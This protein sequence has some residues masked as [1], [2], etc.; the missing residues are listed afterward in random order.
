MSL[1]D[2]YVGRGHCTSKATIRMRTPPEGFHGFSLYHPVFQGALHHGC[3]HATHCPARGYE[4]PADRG[5]SQAAS[6]ALEAQKCS[7]ERFHAPSL[8]NR[9]AFISS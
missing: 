4:S 3:Q 8:S 9:A 6:Y 2:L 1:M 5:S 7:D